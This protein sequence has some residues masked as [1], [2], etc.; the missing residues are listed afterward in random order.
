MYDPQN[1]QMILFETPNDLKQDSIIG[2]LMNKETTTME[3]PHNE[4]RKRTSMGI[5]DK[6]QTFVQLWRQN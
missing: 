2:N 5:E 6:N 4:K 1:T 3:V